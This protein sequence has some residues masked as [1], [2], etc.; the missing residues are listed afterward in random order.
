MITRLAQILGHIRCCAGAVGDYYDFNLR[1]AYRN[2]DNPTNED[3]QY[4]FS[5]CGASREVICWAAGF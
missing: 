2:D 3:P 4:R 1:V 5:L